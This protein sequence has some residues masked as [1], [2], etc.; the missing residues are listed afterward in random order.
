LS[1]IAF[2]Q[3]VMNEWNNLDNDGIESET[4][5]YQF[6]NRLDK[7]MKARRVTHILA[8]PFLVKCR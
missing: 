7:Y 6:K 1:N 4:V 8:L 2:S 3:R 5:T